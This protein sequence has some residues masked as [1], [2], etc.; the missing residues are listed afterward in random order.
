MLSSTI[1]YP[2][3]RISP[4]M[5]TNG[6]LLAFALILLFTSKKENTH[7]KCIAV[8]LTVIVLIITSTIL[9]SYLYNSP[10]LV[11]AGGGQLTTTS[12]PAAITSLFLSIGLMTTIGKKYPPLSAF[13][14]SSLLAQLIRVTITPIVI[15][16]IILNW[17][18]V[19]LFPLNIT[20]DYS[21]IA[22]F[23][24]VVSTVLL[25][26]TIIKTTSKITE[27]INKTTQ[28]LFCTQEKLQNALTYNRGLIEASLDPLVTINQKGII[29][30]VNQATEIATAIPREKLI[31]TDFSSYFTEPERAKKGYKTVL[32]KG[33]IKNY[34]LTLQDSSGNKQIVL[35]NAAIYKDTSGQTAGIFAA[36][37]DITKRKKTEQ[38]LKK[39]M[40]DL[41]RSNEE[42]QQFAYIA[43]H[44]LQ[45]PLRA[46]T[47]YLQL[48]ERRYK[49]KLDTDANDFINFAVDGANKL[50]QMIND[51]LDYSRV[52]SRK[53]PLM[54]I[55]SNTLVKQAIENLKISIE[56]NNAIIDYDNLPTLLADKNQLITV[57][58]NLLSNAIKFHKPGQSPSIHITAEEKKSEWLFGVHDNG[59]GID[60]IY[61]DKL[62]II[63]KRLVGREYPGSGIG[64]AICKRIITRHGGL[65]WVESE[66]EKGSTFYFTIPK[67]IKWTS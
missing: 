28:E 47:S 9:I 66:L 14:G 62:F 45:E 37:R 27:N 8:W 54:K 38:S 5:I 61:K 15:L 39:Y 22:A 19:I 34:E 41:K 26:I 65:I 58:Q 30:D 29:T 33:F 1:S 59:I 32:K 3:S 67:E 56:E 43:S 48:I 60:L 42:L 36:A 17:I 10:L 57:F 2:T 35:Y 55:D 31:G 11:Y 46:V 23:L 18:N 24:C 20:A 12:L 40:V 7:N 16:I 4:I 49:D 50:Q 6:L 21:L 53:E 13:I 25:S 63:F 52:E 64:L 44:D 51:L